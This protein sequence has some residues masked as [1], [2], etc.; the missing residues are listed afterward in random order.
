MLERHWLKCHKK[1]KPE[2]MSFVKDGN[3]PKKGVAAFNEVVRQLEAGALPSAMESQ[4]SV[5]A[6]SKHPGSHSAESEEPNTKLE[7]CDISESKVANRRI[8]RS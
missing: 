1:L 2:K 3:K 6:D 4:K 8:T 7:Q 5:K